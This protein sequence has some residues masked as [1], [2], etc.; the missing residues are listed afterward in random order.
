VD[1]SEPAGA[2][3]TGAAF[4][5]RVLEEKCGRLECH[6]N[7]CPSASTEATHSRLISSTLRLSWAN[8]ARI[9]VGRGLT[10]L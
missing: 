10:R 3:V 9:T 8:W 6:P 2:F 1:L 7:H 4:Y 5:G